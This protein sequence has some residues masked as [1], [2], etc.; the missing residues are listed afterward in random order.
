MIEFQRLKTSPVALSIFQRL[1]L[2]NSRYEAVDAGMPAMEEMINFSLRPQDAQMQDRARQ[3]TQSL[4]EKFKFD[5]N[6]RGVQFLVVIIPSFADTEKY[7]NEF[8]KNY[9]LAEA[10]D[11]DF[12]QQHA[13]FTN[14]FTELG[15]AYLDL[16]DAILEYE[17]GKSA[18]EDCGTLWGDHF[19]PCGHGVTAKI[20][21][22]YI[23]QKYFI[24]Q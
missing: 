20:V 6:E 9:P 1:H 10:K 15:I 2:T 21:S 4:F 22:E 14:M 16:T 19:T 18:I 12:T 24:V 11:F 13:F 23:Q 17:S 8:F 7:K 5:T 3:T